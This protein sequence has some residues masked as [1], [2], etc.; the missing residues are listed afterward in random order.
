MSQA[1]RAGAVP[2]GV[3][4]ALRAALSARLTIDGER[5]ARVVP[6]YLDGDG[7]PLVAPAA[8]GEISAL[9]VTVVHE[10]DAAELAMNGSATALAGDDPA[11]ARFAAFFPAATAAPL[12]FE[13]TR[14]VLLVAGRERARFTYDALGLGAGFA[15]AVE[16]RMVE[17]MNDDHAD[18]LGDY[19]RLAGVPCTAT[20]PR[21]LSVDHDGFF[22]RTDHGPTRFAFD[23]RGTPP[24]DVRLALVD[25][26][27]RARAALPGGRA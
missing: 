16:Q 5:Q 2:R 10:G 23:H 18:A 19:C 3:G 4:Q 25:L 8:D 9:H 22:V 24:S 26:A 15:P 14:C 6:M 20:P 11:L 21:M 1:D 13:P 12:R 27:R 7:R 17:H